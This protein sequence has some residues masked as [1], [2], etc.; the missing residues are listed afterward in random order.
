[1]NE[2]ESKIRNYPVEFNHNGQDLVQCYGCPE[3]D[4]G[5]LMIMT[6]LEAIEFNMSNDLGSMI[7][8]QLPK[9][10]YEEMRGGKI[11]ELD[12]KW[13]VDYMGKVLI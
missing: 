11:K 7:A 2:L 3:G 12:E 4:N 10:I 6:V 9:K 1:M 8:L 5:S 13:F